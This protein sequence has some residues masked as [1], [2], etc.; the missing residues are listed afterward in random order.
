MYYNTIDNRANFF[1]A[2]DQ[3]Y[4]NSGVGVKWFGG[5]DAVSRAIWM[6]LGAGDFASLM[7]LG[8]AAIAAFE[9]NNLYEWR[10]EAGNA[11]MNDG[12]SN[13]KNLYNNGTNN[14]VV[15]DINQLRREQTILQ[16]IHTD[17]FGNTILFNAASKYLPKGVDVTN[18]NARVTYGCNLLGYGAKQGCKP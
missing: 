10:S 14:P 8:G 12:F 17:Y 1:G 6:G 18:Y 4:Q 13:F 5:A 16:P 2:S 7:F 11:L 9:G 3:Y 15:W